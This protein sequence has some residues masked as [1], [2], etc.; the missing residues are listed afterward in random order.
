MISQHRSSCGIY[1]IWDLGAYSLRRGERDAI[2]SPVLAAE[3]RRP[4]F[5]VLSP[6]QLGE[7]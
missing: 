5:V 2:T 6:C 1:V 3:L 7:A 4:G